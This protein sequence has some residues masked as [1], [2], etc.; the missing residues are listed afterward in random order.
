MFWPFLVI[1]TDLLTF[2]VHLDHFGSFGGLE[3]EK[4]IWWKMGYRQRTNVPAT[5]N[6][7]RRITHEQ[8]VSH[9]ARRGCEQTKVKK[10][11]DKIKR[12]LKKFA[13]N[14]QV[15]L[16]HP[17]T[18]EWSIEATIIRRRNKRSYQVTDGVK[19]FPR[20]R[21]FLR[22]R[23]G[24]S[25]VDQVTNPQTKSNK[26]PKSPHKRRPRSHKSEDT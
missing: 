1:F 23:V 6:A 24:P 19:E 13:P 4:F 25:K 8:L 9:L 3:A 7:Y 22:P 15:W 12:E 2:S 10:R 26:G 11:K 14:D 18:K 20:N 21:R 5:P 17:T 16:Q